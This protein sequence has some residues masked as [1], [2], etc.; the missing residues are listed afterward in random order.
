MND[1]SETQ[2]QLLKL[3]EKLIQTR[4]S[5]GRLVFGLESDERKKAEEAALR[6]DLECALADHFDPLL[7]TM[8]QVAGGLRGKL[9]E[10]A[11]DVA[12]LRHRLECLSKSLPRSDHEDAMFEGEMQPDLLTEIKITI[13]TVID[14]QLSDAYENLVFV[15]G[16]DAPEAA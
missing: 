5:L 4:F 3:A 10:A 12:E 8:V 14:D 6:A 13:G 9:L 2:K 16:Y 15:V 1:S 11:L 7:R